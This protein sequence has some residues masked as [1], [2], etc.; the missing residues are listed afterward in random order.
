MKLRIVVLLACFVA[1]L[2]SYAYSAEVAQ[3]VTTTQTHAESVSTS[4]PV[5]TELGYA[6]YAD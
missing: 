4:L 2:L 1:A 6:L 3:A 5:W